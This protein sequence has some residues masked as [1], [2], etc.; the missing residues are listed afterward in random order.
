[1]LQ[2]PVTM[3]VRTMPTRFS[4]RLA[5]PRPIFFFV[6]MVQRFE[7]AMDL[8]TAKLSSAM[9]Y[10]TTISN[11]RVAHLEICNEFLQKGFATVFREIE[12]HDYNIISST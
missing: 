5:D 3:Q 2:R 6:F 10:T 4:G 9:R 12:L 8:D 1:M 7:S 11:P